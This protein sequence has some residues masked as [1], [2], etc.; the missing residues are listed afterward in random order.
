MTEVPSC[1]FSEYLRYWQS[2]QVDNAPVHFYSFPKKVSSSFRNFLVSM[3]PLK[4]SMNLRENAICM[5]IVFQKDG[6]LLSKKTMK[7]LP[8]LSFITIT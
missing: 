4:N 6:S 7:M 8:I 3:V 2:I 1:I 5:K